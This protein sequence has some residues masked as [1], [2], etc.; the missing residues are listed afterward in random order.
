MNISTIIMNSINYTNTVMYE[1]DYSNY[2]QY[3]LYKDCNV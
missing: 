1:Y 3:K 2:K